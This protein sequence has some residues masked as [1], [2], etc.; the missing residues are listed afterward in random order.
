VAADVR[1][2]LPALAAL[3]VVFSAVGIV[4]RR[5][6]DT[7]PWWRKPDLATDLCYA[8]VLPSVAHYGRIVCLTVGLVLFYHANGASAGALLDRGHGPLSALPFAAQVAAY[9]LLADL[10]LYATHRAFHGAPLWR[11]HAVHHSSE[12]LEWISAQRFHPFDLFW[13]AV[14]GDCVLLLLG[15]SPRVLVWLVPFTV[16]MSAL[17]HANLDWDFGPLRAVLASPVYHRWHHTGAAQGGSRNFA[18]NFP[19]F[20]LIFGTYSRPAGQ[21]P[22]RYGVTEGDVPADFAG[23]LLHP[24]RR[25]RPPLSLVRR[26]R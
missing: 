9:L 25:T 21:R 8:L 26:M 6:D 1:A 20:D 3:A 14:F 2:T 22:H 11:Y 23:Q 18:A 15:I 13:H 12:H 4:A 10:G 7:P 19:V 16:G 17:T 5:C 24:F